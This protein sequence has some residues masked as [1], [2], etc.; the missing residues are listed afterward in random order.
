ME[1]NNG[2]IITGGAE[3]KQRLNTLSEVMY[4]Y[5]RS[6]LLSEGLGLCMSFFDVGC[7]GGNVSRMV[8]EI[9]GENGRVTAVDFDEHIITLNK[10][11]TRDPGVADIRY[12]SMSAYEINYRDEFDFAYARFLL[13]HLTEPLNV[14]K[15]MVDSVKPAGKVIVE[16]IHFDG[17]FS[18]P[19]SDAFNEY[20]RLFIAAAEQRGQNA[21]IGPLLPVLF[22]DAGIRNVQFD[23]IQPV[24]K[25]GEGKWMAHIT[26][27]KIKDAVIS[28][29][30]AS[31]DMIQ[32]LLEHLERFTKDE[33]TLI[34]LPRIF[35]VSGVK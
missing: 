9:V 5:T 29:G 6:L 17:H 34:S 14:L 12:Q 4:P 2:Y 25:T 27:D 3:G 23:V 10:Q 16:D 26:M 31:A 15:R 18:H 19:N 32:S 35:R 20:V 28:Q 11:E 8:A 1:T 33:Q 13:S 30:F 7:G 24:F 21:N 22:D